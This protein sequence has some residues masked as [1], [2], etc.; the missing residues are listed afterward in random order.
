MPEVA[1][2]T[3]AGTR[4][5]TKDFLGKWLV[6]YFYPKDKTS[7]CTR[8]AQAFNAALDALR[9]RQAEVVGVSVDSV[10]SHQSFADAYGLRF[11]LISDA[12]KSITSS[13]GLLN[14]KGTSARRTTLLVDPQGRVHRIFENVKV[15]GHVDE[16][17]RAL[18][19]AR[20]APRR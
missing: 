13:L 8:E 7:G 14:E 10:R 11:P 6:L 15:D 9:Q 12:D 3:Q 1:G 18:D 19:E 17:L 4:I 16:V 20:A 5:S 2:L